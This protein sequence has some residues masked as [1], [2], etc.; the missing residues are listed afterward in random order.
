MGDIYVSP[1]MTVWADYAAKS[2]LMAAFARFGHGTALALGVAGCG[3]VSHSVML[4][5]CAHF[6][7]V[8]GMV[9]RWLLLREGGIVLPEDRRLR[10]ELLW[11]V[12]LKLAV[13]YA[14][15]HAFIAPQRVQVDTQA[16]ANAMAAPAAAARQSG[17]EH[18]R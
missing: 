10:R 13:L 5:A 12:V 1:D 2:A 11:V 3:N 6:N 4:A 14:L 17:E 7:P 8:A 18:D 9:C 16:M 15:W